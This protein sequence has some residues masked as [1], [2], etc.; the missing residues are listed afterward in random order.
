VG[1]P[2]VYV[3][4]LGQPGEQLD[5]CDWESG[6]P[7]QRQSRRQVQRLWPIAKPGK[8]FG[9]ANVRRRCVDSVDE[10]PPEFGLP[11]QI[12]IYR[13]LA[14]VGVLTLAPVSQDGRSL[15]GVRGEE[16]GQPRCDGVP[17]SLTQL[18]LGTGIEM[19]EVSRD[20]LAPALVER[21]VEH[22]EERPHHRIGGPEVFICEPQDRG[23]QRTRRREP[24]S[25]TYPV[26]SPW[27]GTQ[28]VR[29]ALGEPALNTLRRH[30]DELFS[31]RV[32]QRYGEHVTQRV[33]EQVCTLGAV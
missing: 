2:D 28:P 19:A 12:V 20:R 10:T 32:G 24:Y 13:G 8:S 14:A 7:E 31:E 9:V 18:R 22:S 3:A 26:A 1:E 33:G 11:G 21:S 15:Y 4:V 25:G 16:P 5:L 30:H 29:K 23:D 17:A 6:M 27:R